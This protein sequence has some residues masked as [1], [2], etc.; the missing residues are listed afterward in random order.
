MNGLSNATTPSLPH[1]LG[2]LWGLS[3]ITQHSPAHQAVH[4]AQ[5]CPPSQGTHLN[6]AALHDPASPA[7]L[8]C[9]AERT[10]TMSPSIS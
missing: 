3:S 8:A 5:V 6:Q 7:A 10:S 4:T 1:S 2:S 9:P